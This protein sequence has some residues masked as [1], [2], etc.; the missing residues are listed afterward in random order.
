M[1]C[2]KI[3][4]S[5]SQ[6]LINSDV[7]IARSTDDTPTQDIANLAE[8]MSFAHQAGVRCVFQLAGLGTRRRP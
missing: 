2:R 1:R 8:N 4:R 5:N 3:L 6:R 7:L